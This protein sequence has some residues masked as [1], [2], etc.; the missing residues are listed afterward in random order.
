MRIRY[1][2]FTSILLLQSAR[3]AT[4]NLNYFV[5]EINSALGYALENSNTV[6]RLDALESVAGDG[7]VL[8]FS[9]VVVS[10]NFSSSAFSTIDLSGWV[11]TNAALVVLE[12]EPVGTPVNSA[13]FGRFDSGA[14]PHGG[15]GVVELDSGKISTVLCVTDGTGRLKA[16]SVDPIEIRMRMA[17]RPG[18]TP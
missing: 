3:A 4:T 16:K 14:D 18:G 17:V 8:T 1:L 7:A 5:G 15:V 9:A 11:G 12:I 10:S 6:A 2:V 13:F